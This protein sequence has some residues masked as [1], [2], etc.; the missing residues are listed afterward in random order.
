MSDRPIQFCPLCGT[1]IEIK[2]YAVKSRPVC[3]SCGWVYFPDPKVAV[4]VVVTKDDRILLVQ[5]RY[6]PETGKWS[7]PAGFMDAYEEPQL[8]AERE[9]REETGLDVKTD[10]IMDLLPGREHAHGA[11]IFIIY[12]ARLVGGEIKAGDDANKAGFFSLQELPPLANFRSTRR[13]IELWKQMQGRGG[14]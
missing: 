9:C 12:D 8:A 11:D 14:S 3:P 6:R 7:I 2:E 10:R 4:G 5:R 13:A 1:P